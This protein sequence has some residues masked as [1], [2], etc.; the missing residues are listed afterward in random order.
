MLEGLLNCQHN[1]SLFTDLI[2]VCVFFSP[3]FIHRARLPVSCYQLYGV[4]RGFIITRE[5][6]YGLVDSRPV[7]LLAQL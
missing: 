3:S 4:W 7:K 2:S 1:A 5:I 6:D